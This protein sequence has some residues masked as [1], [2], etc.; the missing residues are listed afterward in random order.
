MIKLTDL[1]LESRTNSVIKLKKGQK[2]KVVNPFSGPNKI[3][4]IITK[5][6]HYDDDW[7]QFIAMAKNT[8]GT[9]EEFYLTWETEFVN[10]KQ[11]PYWQISDVV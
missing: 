4:V 8:D 7:E 3:E 5:A 11:Q 6:S 1:I 10:K 2:V 9:G